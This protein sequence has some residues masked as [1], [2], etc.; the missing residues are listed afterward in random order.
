MEPLAKITDPITAYEARYSNKYSA[1]QALR[2]LHQA[3][4]VENEESS[5]AGMV[6]LAELVRDNCSS[7]Q[8]VV[9]IFNATT[10]SLIQESMVRTGNT[11]VA[12]AVL[13][14]LNLLN[15]RVRRTFC[16]TWVERISVP[17]PVLQGIKKIIDASGVGSTISMFSCNPTGCLG[18][19]EEQALTD[20]NASALVA[21]CLAH[22]N[23]PLP[24]SI[25]VPKTLGSDDALSLLMSVCAESPSLSPPEAFL[26]ILCGALSPQGAAEHLTSPLTEVSL[27]FL[28]KLCKTPT[29]PETIVAIAMQD[30]LSAVEDEPQWAP[31]V[32]RIEIWLA[33]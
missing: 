21:L 13:E 1:K 20:A 32:K 8:E 29:P 16:I 6:V 31:L 11:A 27:K 10:S 9:N 30:V 26:S 24:L 15:Y 17:V 23:S 14:K 12:I 33:R 19:E 5:T 7:E 2:E 18:Q 22:H 4:V 3:V 25:I 28:L